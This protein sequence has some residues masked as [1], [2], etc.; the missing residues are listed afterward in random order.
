MFSDVGLRHGAEDRLSRRSG[1]P[2]AAG[3]DVEADRAGDDGLRPRHLGQSRAARARVHG[4]RDRRRAEAGHAAQGPTGAVAGRPVL[5]PETA[6]AVRRMLEMAVQPGGTAPKAQVRRLSRRRQDRHRAQARG[7]RLRQ[8]VRVVVRRLRAGVAAAAGRRGDDRRARRPAQYYGGAVAAPV[9]S[10]VMGAALRML[11]VPTDAPVD[12]VILPPEGSRDPRGNVMAMRLTL[13]PSSTSAALLARLGVRCRAGSPPTAGACE[14]GDAFAAYPGTRADG[15]AFIPD[16]IARG[17]GAVLWETRASS[18][19]AGMARAASRGRRSAGEARL[20]S[21]TSS[22][23][24][25]RARCGWSA[26]PAPTARRRAR[27]GSRSALDACGRRAAI[28]GTLGNG[29]V[30]ALDAVDAHDAGRGGAPRDARAASRAGAQRRRDGGVVARAR[31]G[32]RQRRR[33]STSR[34]SPT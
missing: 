19:D 14:P 27:T 22:T 9:F 16:A 29:L 17:A 24:V 1:G 26:S 33:R 10:N 11:G 3:E 21:P 23:A 12:N 7:P 20:R 30:G 13:A 25:R 8:Q 31:P 6:L 15:R 5:K 28:L 18:W 2:A 32:P 34:C 4:V